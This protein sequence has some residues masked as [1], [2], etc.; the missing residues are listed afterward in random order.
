MSGQVRIRKLWS[1]PH[2]LSGTEAYTP[3]FID[4]FMGLIQRLPG[5]YWLTLL[6]LLVLRRTSYRRFPSVSLTAQFP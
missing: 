6:V 4:R 1:N 2:D 3:T 5:P